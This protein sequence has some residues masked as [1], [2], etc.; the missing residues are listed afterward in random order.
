[1]GY[2]CGD[3]VWADLDP[4]VGH[5][6]NKRRPLVVVSNDKFNIHCSLTMTVPI[7][8]A[9]TG[10][11]LHLSV[12]AVPSEDGGTSIHGFAEIEQL[13]SLDLNVRRAVKVGSIDARGMDKILSMVM[14]CLIAPDMS[15]ISGY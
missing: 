6:Q 2:R 9:D 7:I 3:V 10:Y 4:S 8:S 11:P 5:E 14:G 13:K 1:M 15:I 12:G